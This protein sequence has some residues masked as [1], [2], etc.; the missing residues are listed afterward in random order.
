MDRVAAER[1]DAYHDPLSQVYVCF[2]ITDPETP[3]ASDIPHREYRRQ[4]SGSLA[5]PLNGEHE[6]ATR[7]SLTTAVSAPSARARQNS[8]YA[9]SRCPHALATSGHVVAA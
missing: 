1:R 7:S 3:P 4:L 6:G 8:P 5:I 2:S 9:A